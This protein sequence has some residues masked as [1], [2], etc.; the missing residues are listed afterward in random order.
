MTV[1][2]MI[3]L[4]CKQ[5]SDKDMYLMV[6]SI[7]SIDVNDK[8]IHLYFTDGN[9]EDYSIKAESVADRCRECRKN[10]I[11]KQD[12][13]DFYNTRFPDLDDGVHWSRSDIIQNLDSI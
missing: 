4:L 1:G 12:I 5:T 3:A 10:Y 11:C 7:Y 8:E 6:K 2:E 13:I 9:I